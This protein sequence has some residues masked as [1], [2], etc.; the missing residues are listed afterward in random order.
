MWTSGVACA[1]VTTLI[2]EA[3]RL[4]RAS[5]LRAIALVILGCGCTFYQPPGD[6][7]APASVGGAPG[8]GGAKATGGSPNRGGSTGAGGGANGGTSTSTG[9]KAPAG[10]WEDIT[11]DLAGKDVTVPGITYVAAQPGDDTLIAGVT[12]VGLFR[13]DA[14]GETWEALGQGKGSEEIAH[15]VTSIV[16][17]PEDPERFWETGMYGGGGLLT[18]TDGGN[19]FA[20][21]GLEVLDHNDLVSV[22][23]T[24]PDRNTLLV[25]WH[26]Q[27]QRLYRSQDGGEHWDNVGENV[28]ASCGFSSSP[29]VLDDQ[30]FLLGC[31]TQIVR[32]GDAGETWETVSEAGGAGAPLRTTDG[33]IYWRIDSNFGLMFSDNDGIDW[34]RTTEYG[35][36]YGNLLELP[37]GRLAAVGNRTIVVSDD[38][39]RNWSDA[40]TTMPFAPGGVTYSTENRAFYIW[41]ASPDPKVPEE[42]IL[43][44]DWDYEQE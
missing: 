35:V 21:L 22:D 12:G 17:D 3:N 23:F 41:T 34:T 20:R 15:I 9:G 39:G 18:T 1:P 19:T 29:L 36:L 33:S 42:S 16:F 28:P 5:A 26:E 43:K 40:T 25:G 10:T 8:T 4:H 14:N 38:D 7:P 24:D 44:Y 13:G 2:L 6:C 27:K 37:D 30:T 11:G 32:S 31:G